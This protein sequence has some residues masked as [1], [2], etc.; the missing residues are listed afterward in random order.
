MTISK[1]IPWIGVA[2]T[3]ALCVP[4]YAAR[5]RRR[6][7]NDEPWIT[8]KMA[9]ALGIETAAAKRTFRKAIESELAFQVDYAWIARA[10]QAE[11][12]AQLATL[13]IEN[14]FRL[15]AVVESRRPVI[16]LSIHMGSFYFGFLKLAMAVN[17]KREVSVVKTAMA[18]EQE[19]ALHRHAEHKL[20]TIKALRFDEDVGKNVYLAL[21]RGGVVAMMSDVEVRVSSREAVPF[22][23]QECFL[24]SGV[25]RLAV[26]T[27]AM[28]VPVINFTAPSGE[29]ILRIEEPLCSRRTV[30]EDSHQP[31]ITRLMQDIA[32]LMEQWIRID[33]NQ[34]HRWGDLAWT[35]HQRQDARVG[36]I[37]SADTTPAATATVEAS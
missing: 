30:G 27:G 22:F 29:R 31:V 2:A 36:A 33:P 4:V 18:S 25:A 24:Q 37:A 19:S 7:K 32:R 34:F 3:K 6:V 17:A 28:I 15:H 26:T 13:R 9:S 21:R 8:A 1:W 23:G 16:L 12:F 20:G 11:L 10:G 14:L 5:M 35:M